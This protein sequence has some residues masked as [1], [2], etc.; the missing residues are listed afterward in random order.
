M[1]GDGMETAELFWYQAMTEG[2]P[3]DGHVPEHI[4]LLRELKETRR[5]SGLPVP[6]EYDRWALAKAFSS[7]VCRRKRAIPTP[8]RR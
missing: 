2:S 3:H 1:R 7:I 4:L 6:T 8:Q 5:A